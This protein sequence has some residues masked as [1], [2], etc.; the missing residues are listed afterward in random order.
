M[1]VFLAVLMAFAMSGCA[2]RTS[3]GRVFF[4]Q[5]GIVL[6]LIHTCTDRAMVYQAG[7]GFVQEVVG[8][9]PVDIPLQPPV[10]GGRQIQVTVQS[11]DS[12]GKVTGTFVESFS[13]D[14]YSTTTQV[15]VIGESGWS[16]GGRQS[17]CR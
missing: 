16:G 1:R 14:Q 8:A 12:A 11:V 7:P 4:F 5:R 2:V 3:S 13:I 10:L 9:T 15:W 6:Q 17:R